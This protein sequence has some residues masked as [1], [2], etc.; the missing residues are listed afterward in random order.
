MVTANSASGMGVTFK[1]AHRDGQGN[2]IVAFASIPEPAPLKCI[3]FR[4]IIKFTRDMLRYALISLYH[5][6]RQE[7]AETNRRK[8]ILERYRT[9]QPSPTN[10]WQALYALTKLT[11]PLCRKVNTPVRLERA[12]RFR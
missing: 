2:L 11:C 10:I 6:R 1:A 7:Y 12:L 9:G 4:C 8:H 5:E 3:K